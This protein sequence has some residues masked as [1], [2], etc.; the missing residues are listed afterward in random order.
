MSRGSMIDLHTHTDESDGS[1]PPA[2]LVRSAREIGLEALAITDHDTLAGY[3]RAAPVAADLGL[4]LLC[5]IELSTRIEAQPGGRRP[6]SV[7]LLG[8]FLHSAPSTGFR[9]WLE[10]MQES[11]R[12]RNQALVAKLQS[13]GVEITLSEVQAIGR[14]LT[15]RPHFARVL[16][17]KGY[18]ATRQEAFDRYL[19]DHAQAAV[20]REEP[21]LIEGIRQVRAGGGMPSLA[22]PVR[23][24]HAD[25]EWLRSFLSPLCE[26]GL[27]AIE[28][29]HSE[30][31]RGDMERFAELAAEFGLAAT[32]GSDFHGDNKPSVR[33]GTGKHGNLQLPYSLL[34][35]MREVRVA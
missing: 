4:E 21:T 18:V 31:S 20:E 15:G 26:A 7:H 5:G 30:H 9:E 22:H 11:R 1:V 8:Y 29:Y 6:P 12:R 16:V 27:Q 19:A 35:R 23:L 33:L 17:E 10:R 14:N 13:L 25:T 24:P 2:A 32:G 34:E 28:V 3:D